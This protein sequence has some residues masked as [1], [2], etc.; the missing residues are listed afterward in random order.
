MGSGIEKEAITFLQAVLAGNLA[1]LVYSVLR[2][3]RRIIPHNLFW[4]S[5]EDLIFWVW[6][7][8]FLFVR[9]FQTENGNIRWYFVVGVLLGAIFTHKCVSKII[10]KYIA[11]RKKRE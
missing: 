1:Y 6:T 10:K 3:L 8:I 4:I 2:V 9:V 5:V 11:K 7:G